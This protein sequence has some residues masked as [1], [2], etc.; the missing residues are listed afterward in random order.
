MFHRG[1]DQSRTRRIAA[2]GF[3]EDHLSLAVGRAREDRLYKLDFIEETPAGGFRRGM[4]SDVET[5]SSVLDRLAASL[6]RVGELAKMMEE[7]GLIQNKEGRLELTP[8]GLRRL[9]QQAHSAQ[10]P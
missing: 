2:I 8:R 7:Q 3:E 6:E 9:G 10:P 4:I 5:F 1:T